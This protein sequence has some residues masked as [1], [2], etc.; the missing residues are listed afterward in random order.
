MHRLTR[1]LLG[2]TILAAALGL[3]GSFGAAAGDLTF[4]SWGGTTQD[5]QKAA[6]ADK[7]EAQYG[8]KVLQDG[9]TDYGKLKAMIDANAVTW[10]VVDVEPD[11]AFQAAKQGLLE[12]LDFSV[13][14]KKDIDPRFVF[15]HGVGSFY[16]SFVL[17]YN[18][19]ALGGKAPA[20]WADLFDTAK[21]P[22]K[23]TFY[24][25]ASPGVLEVA[26][27]ADGVAPDKLYPLDLDR[28][29]KKLDSIKKD[30]LWWG[31]GAESQQQLASGEAPLGMFWNGRIYALQKDGAKVDVV[32]NQNLATADF[33]VVPKGSK[34]K[35]EAMK[36][37]AIAAG[38]QGQ[39]DLATAT[40]YA[41]INV[42]SA[43]MLGKEMAAMLPSQ[44]AKGQITL[45]LDYWA[46]HR[47]EIGKR[48]YA[49]QAK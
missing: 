9:P 20:S 36:F 30:I 8:V 42:K 38:A 12:P 6:W 21:F 11:F 22:G 2:A 40:G 18:P 45:D 15:D 17:G 32:W 13:I 37:I 19:D 44:H 41:P 27:L 34:N 26:L 4:T 39:A 3:G 24:K 33:L 29:F 35:A 43:A 5:A 23:R 47:D 49:W 46:A 28:A 7:F 25:W 48:W 1:R 16:F 31:S 14:D 10:D